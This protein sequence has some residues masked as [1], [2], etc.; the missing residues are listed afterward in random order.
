VILVI[1]SVKVVILV[2][3]SVK[4]VILVIMSVKTLKAD[5][6]VFIGD[7]IYICYFH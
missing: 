5:A 3:M 4:V 2:I 7:I 6:I 1:V